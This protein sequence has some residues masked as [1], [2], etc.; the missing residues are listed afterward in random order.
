[1]LPE[2]AVEQYCGVLDAVAAD[3]LAEAQVA[4]PPVDAFRV[5]ATLGIAVA[6]DDR[7]RGRARCAR[8]R[9]HRGRAPQPAILV[10]HDSRPERV[11]WAAAHEIG[12]HYAHRVFLA[13]GVDPREGP[14]DL[15]ERVADQLAG[16]ILLP[17]VW[18]A[19]DGAA[20]GWDLLALKARYATASHEPIARRM[21]E[22]ATPVIVSIFD[23]GRLR[24]RRTNAPGC[25]PPLSATEAACW[26][27]AHQNNR[28]HQICDEL[29][30]VQAWPIHE[31][32]WKRE[33]LRTEVAEVSA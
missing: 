2:I 7:Q 18:F 20:T 16:R 3:V 32:G 23:Q 10:R 33:I 12:E 22:M 1:M 28:P 21:L 11:Q 14:A 25:V 30:R 8:L 15:R 17:V 9:G 31:D 19:A 5:A 24:F 27:A 13:L 29:I 26:R 4:G 6:W